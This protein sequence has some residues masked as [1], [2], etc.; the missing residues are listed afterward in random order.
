MT[1]YSQY[2]EEIFLEQFFDINKNGLVVDIGAADGIRYS[3]SR[4]LIEKGWNGLLIEPNPRNFEKLKKLYDN[5]ISV[6]IENV[7]CGKETLSNVE[8]F[9]DKNDEFEQLSTFKNEQMLK[10]KTIYNC[11]FETLS[12]KVIKTS[13]IF[14][15]YNI[16]NIDFVSID[17]EDFDQNVIEGIDFSKVNIKLICI[18]HSTQVIEDILSNHNYHKVHKTIGNIFYAK[19]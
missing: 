12:T 6:L 2:G 13:E 15:K 9:I 7:G 14:N 5:N 18:E 1:K 8:F 19:K 17:T 11:D 16:T 10:C 3:N 4:F